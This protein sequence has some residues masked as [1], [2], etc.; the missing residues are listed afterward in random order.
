[1]H[2]STSLSRPYNEEEVLLF[3]YSAIFSTVFL[4]LVY[5]R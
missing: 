1:R 3:V 5:L 4:T 2:I